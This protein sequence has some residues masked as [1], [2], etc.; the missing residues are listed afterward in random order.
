MA[1]VS[2]A[3]NEPAI[4]NT[5]VNMKKPVNNVV[6]YFRVLIV[7]NLNIIALFPIWYFI[8][9]LGFWYRFSTRTYYRFYDALGL[10]VIVRNLL[11]PFRRDFTF[12]GYLV[13]IFIRVVWLTLGLIFLC[14]VVI[15]MLFLICAFY[16]APFL[17]G[18]LKLPYLLPYFGVWLG[19]YLIIQ[20][21][22]KYWKGIKAG[23][24]TRQLRF[25]VWARMEFN[26][27]EIEPIYHSSKNEFV[28]FLRRNKLNE[29][30]FLSTKDW[31]LRREYQKL[32]WQ[33]WRD[34]F[35][36]R[37]LG[38]N[39]GFVAGFLPELK[40]Y[41]IDLTK[42]AVTGNLPHAFGR[43]AEIEKM[44]TVLSRPGK[45]NVLLIGEA[46]VGKTSLIYSLAWLILGVRNGIDL[47]TLDYLIAPIKGR[48]VIELNTGGMVGA[49]SYRGSLEARFTEVLRELTA[50]ETILFV[51][52]VE[53]IIQAGL[54]GYLTPI[55]RSTRFPIIATTTTK[56]FNQQLSNLPEFTSEFEVI[57]LNPP[58]IVESIRIL[59]GVAD[60]LERKSHV[61]VT[62]PALH[63]IVELSERYI[64]NSVMPDK[65]VKVMIKAAELRTHRTLTVADVQAAVTQ[66][67]GVPVGEL[68]IEESDKLLNLEQILRQRIIGQEEAI[69]TIARAMRRSR[70]GVASQ[71]RPIASLMFLGPTGVGKTLTAKTLAQVYFTPQ[72]VTSVSEA[73]L[74]KLVES[75]F[76]RFDMSEFSEYGAV[77]GFIT[78]L[79]QQIKDRPFCL[80]LLDEF[81]KAEQAI[82]NLFLQIIEDG[83][84]TN[85]DGETVDF[86]NAI[87]IATSNAV[88]MVPADVKPDEY[89]RG[90]LQEHFRPELINRFDGLVLFNIIGNTEIKRIVAIELSSLAKRLRDE[91]EIKLTWTQQLQ[92]ELA[93]LGYDP[94]YGARPLRR[95]I[96]DRLEDS[97]AQKIL[98]KQLQFGDE[99]QLTIHDL[100]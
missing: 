84:L 44:L 49:T 83:R 68:S 5:V 60:Q 67:S 54:I 21:Y 53:N 96:Q 95:V 46:G 42:E 35:Y 93:K 8:Y 85:D 52:Q 99:Y 81:E 61:F 91:H 78:R 37:K 18:Y 66:I 27:K 62:Y 65:G 15:L 1:Y 23:H 80:V 17:V 71:N 10:E 58:S 97:L 55:V 41:S 9:S 26:P 13:G 33:Y 70:A 86:R 69:R 14:G 38:V 89:V 77:T 47:P 40:K 31:V 29:Q 6:N 88:T 20:G 28:M 25:E 90:K 82:H 59:E 51:N 64:H 74:T 48:R 79:T 43:E 98:R 72:S 22:E 3:D 45:N 2:V 57:R 34:D 73:Q 63:S 12:A 11:A 24:L 39:V 36:Y 4:L 100:Q 7:D 94:E 92:D 50:G 76:V 16:G 56:V 32:A 19:I 87:I 75:S 30:D